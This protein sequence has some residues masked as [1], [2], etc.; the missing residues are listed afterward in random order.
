MGKIIQL[1]MVALCCGLCASAQA[2]KASDSYLS[3][4]VS[5]KQISGQW[6]IALR[7]L[8]LVVGLDG[9]GNGLLTWD[10]IRAK[11]QQIEA[12]ALSRLHVGSGSELGGKVGGTDESACQLK[13]S[14]L[15][16]DH[17]SDGAY[18]V[19]RLVGVCPTMISALQIKY[20][21]LFEFDPQHKGLLNLV[22]GGQ[23]QTAIFSPEHGTQQIVVAQHGAAGRQWQQWQEYVRHGV[24]HIWIGYDHILFLISLL[25]PAVLVFSKQQW[26]V[27]GNFKSALGE[28]VKVVSA[29]T[30][31]HSIT[32]TLASLGVV[33]LPSRWVESAIA[34]S[35]L[36]A[37]I[38][39]L[40]PMVQ[41]RRW[42]AA[43][44]F[45]LIHGFG[46]ASV[47]TDLG[48]EQGAFT[49]ALLGF[50]VGVEIGQ[51]CIVGVFLPLAFYLRQTW[52]YRRVVFQA[53]SVVIALLSTGWMLQRAL[54]IKFDGFG[55]F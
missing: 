8:E 50:N 32:L 41:G 19:L 30:L 34:A 20:S 2:H 5:G 9:D 12:Y 40:Y 10:E 18:A 37:A 48:L 43:F 28:V 54:D 45:G 31:A 21:L 39:N 6:D 33:N 55:L 7:D 11:R 46:F 36:V 23:T 47:L 44:G 29:F 27:V 24:W 14:E 15:L 4:Q 35:V 17:H 51:L 22:Q 25:L 26:H 13:A 42:V 3:L 38:N 52:V 53:G 16:I 49:L 1:L